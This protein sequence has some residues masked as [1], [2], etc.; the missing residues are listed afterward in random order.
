M[1]RQKAELPIRV[2]HILGSI[3]RGGTESVVFNNYQY[4]DRSK[5]QFDIAIDDNSPCEVPQNIIDMGCRIYR[6]PPYTKQPAYIIAIREICLK[7]RYQIVHSHMNAMSIFPLFAVWLAKVPVRI[8]HS[9]STAAKGKGETKRNIIKYVLR[10][11][12]KLFATHYFACSEHAARWLFGNRV[13]EKG[14]VVILN[15]AISAKRFCYNLRTRE[16]IRVQI[17][18]KDK[19]VIGHVGRFSP[20]KNHDFLI[21]VF[22][23]VI[24]IRDNAHLLLIG[25]IGS[26][27]A[28]I[29]ERVRK[30]LDSYG[31]TDKVSFL[32]SME[33][34][35]AFYQAMDVFILP[36]LYEGLGMACIEAQASGLPCIMSDRIPKEVQINEN[37]KFLSL[38]ES[39]ERWAYEVAESRGIR[40]DYSK[41]IASAGYDII[42]VANTLQETYLGYKRI[43]GRKV[44]SGKVAVISPDK[45]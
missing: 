13:M 44:E 8:S 25:G 37:V 29:E 9:H 38:Y 34:I 24:K 3:Q 43:V 40:G 42:E 2:L 33:N 7:N 26:A 45:C 15:N 35:S 39:A 5:V 6:I 31:I 11:F 18:I 36:S 22:N 16:E 30:K 41:Q 32:G 10:P 14:E 27:G 4:I 20:P 23:D 21:D 12:S 1:E 19:F 17:G 28:G